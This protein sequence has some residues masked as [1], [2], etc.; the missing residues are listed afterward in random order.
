M[1]FETKT[2]KEVFSDAIRNFS[3][4]VTLTVNLLYLGYLTYAILRNTGIRWINISLAVAT[5]IFT[6]ANIIFRMQGKR[7]KSGAKTA[8]HWYKRFKLLTKLFSIIAAIYGIITALGSTT[9]L[10]VLL[11][12]ITASIWFFQVLLEIIVSAID[13]KIEKI[14]K[15]KQDKID[16]RNSM[17]DENYKDIN[18]VAADAVVL[19]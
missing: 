17:I 10:T 15:R 14:K 18:D 19:E 7:G 1:S 4:K 8:K 2:A 9:L 11:S 13:R 12:Y 16:R 5:V 6:I 3:I